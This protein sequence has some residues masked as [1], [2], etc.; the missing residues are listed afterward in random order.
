MRPST[1]GH[2]LAQNASGP[3]APRLS[4]GSTLDFWDI[5]QL[6]LRRWRIS[7]PLLLMTAVLTGVTAVVVKPTYVAT[8]YVEL[9]PPA[10]ITTSNG[11]I[12]IDLRNPWLNQGLQGLGFAA[13][14][15]VQDLAYLN[16]L[17]AAGYSDKVE[18]AMGGSS[19]P[20][21][22][23]AV[24]GA[25]REQVSA[26]VTK[27][28]GRFHD[29]IQSLQT[30]SGIAT[31]DLVTDLRLDSTGNVTPSYSRVKRAVIAIAGLG[32]LLTAGV[33]M[34]I[35]AWQRRRNE[36]KLPA[37]MGGSSSFEPADQTSKSAAEPL[38]G[39]LSGAD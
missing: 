33:T 32:L 30:D 21:V 35:N 9:V 24:N 6:L 28:V 14:V 26:T 19:T 17:K 2:G 37:E 25:T 11:T 7:L 34:A 13:L 10:P 23:F 3:C 5:T 20:V 36:A 16:T 27:V 38:V 39:S 15:T 31:V 1:R 29:S 18:T 4:K 12:A 8:A 22:I